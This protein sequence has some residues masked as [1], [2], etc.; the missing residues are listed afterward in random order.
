LSPQ[1]GLGSLNGAN[2]LLFNGTINPF[3]DTIANPPPLRDY[4][5]KGYETRFDSSGDFNLRL[6]GPFL[7]LPAGRMHVSVALGARAEG[8]STAYLWNIP[9]P[10]PGIAT[11]SEVRFFPGGRQTV[12]GAGVEAKIPVV[13]EKNNVL[14]VKSLDLQFAVRREDF[15]QV[16]NSGT[17][18]S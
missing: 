10:V 13:A 9:P 1:L 16:S 6:A 12:Q 14:L 11:N 3:V 17:I 7:S 4:Y 15:Q 8:F 18:T 5:F 2:A